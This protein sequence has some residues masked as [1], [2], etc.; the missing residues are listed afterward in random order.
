MNTLLS[1]PSLSKRPEMDKY[2]D[3][4]HATHLDLTIPDPP[5]NKEDFCLRVQK[6]MLKIQV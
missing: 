2:E 5:E 1:E 4:K 3:L 6:Q